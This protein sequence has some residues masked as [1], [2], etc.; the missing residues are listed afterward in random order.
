V[1]GLTLG[2]VAVVSDKSMLGIEPDVKYAQN[3]EIVGDGKKKVGRS[4]D[5]SKNETMGT[6]CS[7]VQ[8]FS[9][10]ES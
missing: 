8:I 2:F 1:I 9:K 7:L 6:T 5:E 4:M 10:V 3:G